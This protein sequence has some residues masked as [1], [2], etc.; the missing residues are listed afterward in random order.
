[1]SKGSYM[2][3]EMIIEL[4][5]NRSEKAI[6]ETDKKYGAYCYRVSFN[7]LSNKEDAEE[8][9]SD[10]YLKTWN[11]IP[12]TRPTRFM[13]FLGKIT[14]NISL[15]LLKMNTTKKRGGDLVRVIEEELDE[16]APK[17]PVEEEVNRG[18]LLDCIN[19]Y[20]N[21]QTEIK[22]NIFVRRYWYMDTVKA[23]SDRYKMNES[24]VSTILMKMRKELREYLMKEGF[25]YEW[26]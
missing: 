10:T 1:M 9:V 19:A 6:S 20:L 7:V 16:C 23:I 2:K 11:S 3:D 12:P 13:A 14:R 21:R 25:T 17:N 18:L 22:A 4:Y 26:S 5:W 24:T 8:C 15:N